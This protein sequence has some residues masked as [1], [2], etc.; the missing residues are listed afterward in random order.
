[1]LSDLGPL[2]TERNVVRSQITTENHTTVDWRESPGI[3]QHCWRGA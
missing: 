1:M 2:P 3:R